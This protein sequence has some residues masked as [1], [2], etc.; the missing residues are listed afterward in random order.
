[1]QV[2]SHVLDSL[3]YQFSERSMNMSIGLV[4]LTILTI[5]IIKALIITVKDRHVLCSARGA[6]LEIVYS[7]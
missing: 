7:Q 1:M 3:L 5:I 4:M 6:D 2:S